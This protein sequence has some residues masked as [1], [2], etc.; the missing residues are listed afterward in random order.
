[1]AKKNEDYSVL[2][3]VYK[4]EKPEFLRESMQS[5]Y[6]QTVP[7]NDFVLICDGP[8]TDGLDNV[9]KE[10]QKKF[11]KRLRVV[12]LDKNCGLGR[13]LNVGVQECKNELIARMDSDDISVKKRIEKQLKTLEET[14]ADVVGSNIA[15]YDEKMD[16]KTGRRVVPQMRDDI[17]KRM[18]KRNPMNHMTVIYKKSKVIEAGN[19]LDMPGFEDYYLW[20]RMVKNGCRFCNIEEDLVKVRGGDGMTKRRSGVKYIETIRRFEKAIHELGFISSL[21]CL[22]NTSERIVIASIP[23]GVRFLF[24]RKALRG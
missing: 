6:D 18:K 3:S 7:T 21:E 4:K 19:Y 16:K 2:M 10:M 24:Y 8:L 17:V 1:M 5:M 12:R 22:V 20:V 13:A 11:D 9:I 15:E 14:G 23:N